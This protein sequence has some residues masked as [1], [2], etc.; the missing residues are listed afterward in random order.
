MKT[1]FLLALFFLPAVAQD[2]PQPE[3]KP[4]EHALA[5][6]ELDTAAS[7]QQQSAIIEGGFNEVNQQ[8][9]RVLT[10]DQKIAIVD[11]L[12]LLQMQAGQLQEGYKAFVNDLK[13]KYKCATCELRGNVFAEPT[14]KK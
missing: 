12:Q 13:K 11:K 6:D 8:L 10:N 2:K 1:L 4:A 9:R 5:K 7:F 3:K 14:E